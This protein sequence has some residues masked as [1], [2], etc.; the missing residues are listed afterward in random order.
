MV[1]KAIKKPTVK[2][3]KPAVVVSLN[4]MELVDL[5]PLLYKKFIKEG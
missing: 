5:A 4:I 3:K 1:R 2:K